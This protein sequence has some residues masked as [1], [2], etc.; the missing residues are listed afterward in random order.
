MLITQF[1]SSIRRACLKIIQIFNHA[2]QRM[3][4]FSVRLFHSFIQF[5]FSFSFEQQNKPHRS[6]YHAGFSEYVKFH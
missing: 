3:P 2:K 5:F 1:I 4:G 6:V